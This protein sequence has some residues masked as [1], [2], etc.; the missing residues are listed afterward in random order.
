VHP[1]LVPQMADAEEVC[2]RLSPYPDVRYSG[3]A[4]NLKGI[5]RAQQAGIKD[6]DMSVSASEAHS[7]RNAN[8]TVSEALDEYDSMYDRARSYN[9]EVRG[10]IQCAFGFQDAD[11]VDPQTVV[12]IARHFLDD[13]GVDELALADSSGLANPIQLANL[14]Q[15]IVP[16]AGEKP[17]ILHLHDTRG[18][19]LA[20]VVEAMRVGV[21]CFDTSFGGLGGCPFIAD[22]T[23]NIA[24]EDT[25]YML[26]QMGIETGIDLPKVSLIAKKFE[27]LLGIQSLPGKMHSMLIAH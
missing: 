22:A 9:M 7:L 13:L 27:R 2:A 21:R 4:L 1:R 16:M 14:L 18:M 10:G 8:R 11:D 5:D 17:V 15:V 23:G 3:L 19:G 25:A 20:N 26:H 24:T 6:I 12:E